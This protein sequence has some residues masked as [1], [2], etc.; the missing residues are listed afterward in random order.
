MTPHTRRS[1]ADRTDA[2]RAL[3]EAARTV[4]RHRSRWADAIARTTGLSREGVE[5]GFTRHLETDV[6]EAELDALVA[7][8][9]DASV[10]HV[11]LSAN[12]FT[13]PLRAIALARAAAPLVVVRPSRRDPVLARALAEVSRDPAITI[14]DELDVAAIS[15]GE[16]HVYGRD[17]T[18]AL[19]RTRARAGVVVR[20]HGAG[21]GV[22]IVSPSADLALAAEALASDV[23]AFDQRGC[24]SPRIV[25][26][27]GDDPRAAELSRALHEALLAIA[28]RVPRG[29]LTPDERAEGA[30]WVDAV[31]FAGFAFRAADHVVGFVPRVAP[32]VAPTGRHVHVC[33]ASTESAARAY[34]APFA[35]WI[36]AVGSDDPEWASDLAPPHARV[37]ALGAMQRPPLDGPVDRRSPSPSRASL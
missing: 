6:T 16:I 34:L 2:V 30:R 14:V 7:A 22:A 18:I 24:L 17:E 15:T 8:A 21:M 27:V 5:L 12:V 20:G 23:V 31:T 37:S 19:L 33:A 13:A 36:V 25:I 35:R 3:L 1:A 9:G 10:V 11:V 29:V 28:E 4:V 26:A 32:I